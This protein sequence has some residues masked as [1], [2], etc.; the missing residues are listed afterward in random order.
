VFALIR[1]LEG[2]NTNTRTG[3]YIETLAK[4]EISGYVIKGRNIQNFLIAS[5]FI[6]TAARF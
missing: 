3:N 4:I 2:S 1:I 5:E 6:K